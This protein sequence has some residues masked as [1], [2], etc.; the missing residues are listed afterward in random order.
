MHDLMYYS[1]HSSFLLKYF[2]YQIFPSLQDSVI[3]I[4]NK[5]NLNNNREKKNKLERNAILCL[6]SLVLFP[7]SVDSVNHLLDQLYLRVPKSVFVG[8]VISMSSLATRFSSGTSGLKMKLLT[9]GLE[10]INTM[11]SPSR[12]INMDRCSHAS[13]KIGGAGMNVTIL[14][15][16]AEALARFLHDRVSNSLDTLGKS[17]KDTLDITTILHRDDSQLV[18]FIDPDEEGL[19]VIV[20]NTTTLRPV[21]LHTSNL[22]VSV[23]RHK[24]EV[25]INKLLANI[26]SHA[27]Q[28]VIV[29]S[30]ISREILNSTDHKFFN[31]NTLLFSDSRRKAKTINGSSNPDSGRMNWNI[32]INV[33]F[34]L[35]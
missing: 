4:I 20:E 7:Q 5:H 28:G 9:P 27:S 14:L 10:L 30:K 29:T 1:Y 21:T 31:T 33:S 17:L 22:E 16:Q 8:D 25:I 2:S 23:S 26:L 3:N 15:I 6:E 34:N 24:Q 18:F 13:T 12:E 35:A 32:S 19:L 11:L